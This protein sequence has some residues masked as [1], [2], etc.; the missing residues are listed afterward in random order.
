MSLTISSTV[1]LHNGVA[2]PLFGLGT[3][4]SP[5]GSATRQAVRYALEIGYRLIDTASAY[6][7]EED[8]GIAIAESPVNRRELFVTS[9]AWIDEQGYESTK[10]ACRRSLG[11]LG[12]DYLDLYLIH[13]PAPGV[14][15][16]SWR[17]MLD[18]QQAG[19]CCAVGVSNF[20]VQHLEELRGFSAQLP[21]VNQVEFNPFFYRKD[22]LLYCREHQIQLEG[23]SPLVRGAKLNHPPLVAIARKH[24]K[25]AGQILLRWALQHSVVTIPKSI[26]PDHLRANTEIFDF[27]ISPEDMEKLDSLNE[28]Y[29]VVQPEFRAR[30][31]Q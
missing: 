30:F 3:F 12:L 21:T 2:M 31:G 4:R 27:E 26:N 16:D 9:K 24:G 6:G 15:H 22:I 28:N 8:I 10:E 20:T 14:W 23:Y 25:T 19:L 11:R 17:A 7:N 5:Q 1:T 29:S 13:W 18:L